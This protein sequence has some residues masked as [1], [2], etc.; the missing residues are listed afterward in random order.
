MKEHIEKN[1]KERQES[2]SIII[3]QIAKAEQYLKQLKAQLLSIRGGIIELD[4]LLK[5]INEEEE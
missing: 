5:E 3:Q 1:M 4:I 2:E